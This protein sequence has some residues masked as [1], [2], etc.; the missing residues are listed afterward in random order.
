MPPL[1]LE[2]F[3]SDPEAA[4]AQASQ[5]L[6]LTE[7]A[8]LQAY[9]Q[10]YGAGWED[11]VTAQTED[12]SRI[13][14]DLA[15]NLQALGF[16]Y[17]EARSHVLRAVAPLLQDMIGQLLPQVAREALGPTVLDTLLPMAE[18]LADAPVSV[19]LNPAA[20]PAVEALLA[21][22]AL[23]VSITEEPTLGEGQVYL[24]L[25]PAETHVD[26]D[27]ATALISQAVRGFFG[28][29]EQEHP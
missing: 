27:R 7:D 20:R 13:R 21:Q 14:A 25:G 11:A 10:G 16:T 12:Q 23:P 24:R 29:S 26:L 2:S 8:R 28:L 4:V 6:V 9:E 18:H 15:R 3:E 5:H 17:H 19:V 1:K 22:T